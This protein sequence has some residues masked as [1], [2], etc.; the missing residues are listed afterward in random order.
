M[1]LKNLKAFSE[2]VLNSYKAA[3][4]RVEHHHLTEVEAVKEQFK[5]IENK[6][7]DI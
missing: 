3:L 6:V 5:I 1:N 7:L 4:D 2:F